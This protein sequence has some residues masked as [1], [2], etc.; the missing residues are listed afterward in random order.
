MS[1]QGNCWDNAVAESFFRTLK[2]EW[3]YHI[4]LEDF[5]HTKHELFEYIEEFYNNKRLHQT[6]DYCSPVAFEKQKN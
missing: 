2:T 6:L 5:D 4:R 3:A 1:R